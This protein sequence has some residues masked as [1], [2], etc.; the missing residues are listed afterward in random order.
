MMIAKGKMECEIADT[1]QTPPNTVLQRIQRLE[2]GAV[3][4]IKRKQ[5]F[6]DDSSTNRTASQKRF[7]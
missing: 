3:I 7:E 2:A 1:L 5:I 6:A 4:F